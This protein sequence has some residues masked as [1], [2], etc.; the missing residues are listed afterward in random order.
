M[1]APTPAPMPRIIG[2]LFG[3]TFL[4]GIWII[5]PRWIIYPLGLIL[6]YL[7]LA[8]A[9]MAAQLIADVDKSLRGLIAPTTAAAPAGRAGPP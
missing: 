7:F 1:T 5:E 4:F 9:P 6:L 8:K 2:Y 3:G